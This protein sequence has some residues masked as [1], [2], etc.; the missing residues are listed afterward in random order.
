M[1]L[2]SPR[3]SHAARLQN[4]PTLYLLAYISAYMY[5]AGVTIHSLERRRVMERE[6]G[7]AKGSIKGEGEGNGG[8]PRTKGGEVAAQVVLKR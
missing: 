3:M 4:T 6:R 7:G 1:P 8:G 5:R 2:S